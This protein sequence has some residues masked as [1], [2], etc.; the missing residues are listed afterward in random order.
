MNTKIYKWLILCVAFLVTHDLANAKNEEPLKVYDLEIDVNPQTSSLGIK[1]ELDLKE[2]KV[3]RNS[4]IIFT[5]VLMADNGQDSLVFDPIT[6]CGRTR[7]Y[8]YQREGLLDQGDAGIYRAGAPRKVN[9]TKQ[10]AF[11][12]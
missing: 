10:V 9:I 6:I 8:F 12:D 7:W 1:I 3:N 2:F 5:P 4:E 11:E